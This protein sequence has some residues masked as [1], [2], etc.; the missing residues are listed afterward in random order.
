MSFDD[1]LAT[2]DINLFGDDVTNSSQNLKTKSHKSGKIDVGGYRIEVLTKDRNL[3]ASSRVFKNFLNNLGSMINIFLLEREKAEETGRQDLK[4]L[5][6]NLETY[7]AQVMQEISQLA[8]Q[9]LITKTPWN[10]KIE[11]VQKNIQND[12]ILASKAVLRLG[13]INQG[14]KTELSVFSKLDKKNLI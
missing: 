7:N 8:P 12:I 1:V 5:I 14:I 11:F 13:R 3:I 10:E 2:Q 9:L 4:R 6:H